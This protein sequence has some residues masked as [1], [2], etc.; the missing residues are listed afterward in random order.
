VHIGLAG[1]VTTG[2]A[3]PP[4]V[5]GAT[6]VGGTVLFIT[7]LVLATTT[8]TQVSLTRVKLEVALHC[9]QAVAFWH[10]IQPDEHAVQDALLR[11]NPGSQAV[12]LVVLFGH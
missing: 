4:D 12:Q 7:L 3:M 8:A 10:A 5:T 6:S 11:K 9:V 2:G 1:L